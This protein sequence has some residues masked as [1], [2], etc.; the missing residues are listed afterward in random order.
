MEFKG[1]D[2]QAS[3]GHGGHGRGLLVQSPV[4][5]RAGVYPAQTVAARQIQVCK[6]AKLQK[7]EPMPYRADDWVCDALSEVNGMDGGEIGGGTNHGQ[8]QPPMELRRSAVFQQADCWRCLP[9]NSAS[10]P[11][12][13]SKDME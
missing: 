8:W 2:L 9:S 1:E 6:L 12:K 5:A 13:G 11:D 3:E 4:E 7:N 10:W